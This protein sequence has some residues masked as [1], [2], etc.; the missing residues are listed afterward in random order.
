ML[1]HYVGRRHDLLAHDLCVVDGAL[2]LCLHNTKFGLVGYCDLPI[3]GIAPKC[4]EREPIEGSRGRVQ[5]Q[6]FF[7]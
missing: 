6:P 3:G 1:F 7:S 2:D 4:A 5:Q